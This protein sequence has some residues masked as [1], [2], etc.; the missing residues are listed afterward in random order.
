MSMGNYLRCEHERPYV[1]ATKQPAG[2]DHLTVV[3]TN[4]EPD[5]EHRSD[6][7]GTPSEQ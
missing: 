2:M 3:P 4:F 7:G 1:M 6:D 5:A